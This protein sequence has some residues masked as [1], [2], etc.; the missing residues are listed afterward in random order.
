LFFFYRQNIV[1]GTLLAEQ[2]SRLRVPV[3]QLLEGSLQLLLTQGLVTTH[4]E[5]EATQQR[6]EANTRLK[7]TRLGRAC[8]Q[9]RIGLN[10]AFFNFRENAKIMRK[11]DDFRKNFREN[12]KSLKFDSD[13]ACMVHVV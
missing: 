1:S 8:I 13:T 5:T 2:A 7:P 9:V 11:W 6:V 3:S 10:N 12:E 4:E